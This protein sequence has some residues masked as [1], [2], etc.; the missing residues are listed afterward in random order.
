MDLFQSL[1]SDQDFFEELTSLFRTPYFGERSL[2]FRWS[3]DESV[4]RAFALSDTVSDLP[5]NLMN[6]DLLELGRDSTPR[7]ADLSIDRELFCESGL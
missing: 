2:K 7:A 4:F 3:R 5:R 6:L 1:Q